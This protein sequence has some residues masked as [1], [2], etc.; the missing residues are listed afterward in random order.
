MVQ[1]IKNNMNILDKIVA[2]KRKE[3]EQ[4]KSSVSIASYEQMPMFSFARKSLRQSLLKE[5]STGIIAEFKRKSP[6]KGIINGNADVATVTSTYSQ[7]AAGISVLTDEPFFG[8]SN[9]DLIAARNVVDV[10]LLRK[11]FI[12]DEYQLYE[13]RA[14]GA[15]VILLIAACLSQ[16]QVKQLATTARQ[17]ELEVLLEIHNEEELANI[18]DE[19]NMI[20][21]NN[22]NLKTFEVDINTSLNLITLLPKEKPAIAESGIS[23]VN[24]IKALRNA[25]FKGFLIGEN[26]MKNNDPSIAF[27]Q[28]VNEL[29]QTT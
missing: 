1:T 16:Q 29:K 14:I 20:G 27:I 5:D 22:R 28:F 23:N 18:C 21:V 9:D 8:G 3:I 4:K 13:A 24:A 19:V 17:L 26:F 12:V 10:P 25:G 6:S 11:D 2:E 15:D 7:Q